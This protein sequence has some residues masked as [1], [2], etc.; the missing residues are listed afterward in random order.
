VHGLV[1]SRQGFEDAL[2]AWSSVE[3]TF[4]DLVA[5]PD[6]PT[7][8][9]AIRNESLADYDG[10]NVVQFEDPFDIIP[11]LSG[12][13]GIV[14]LGGSITLEGNGFIAGNTTFEQTFE[15][16]VVMNQGFGACF[17]A[18]AIA[19]TV[20][21]EIGHT[22][23]FGH[24]SE[25][26]AE[27]DPVLEDAIMYFAIKD[28]GRGAQLG[29]DDVAAMLFAYPP[30]IEEP[31]AEGTALRNAACLLDIDLW[32]GAC[33]VD[34]EELSGFPAAPI[35]QYRKA[36]RLAAKAYAGTKA[37]KQLKLVKKADRLLTKA[38]TKLAQLEADG[39]LRTEC[40]TPLLERVGRAR[41]RIG[42]AR[43]LLEAVL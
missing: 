8:P 31:S 10:L 41:T 17:S 1:A 3:G 12:C 14:A 40:V 38:E 24:S 32:S 6:V 4:L 11:D 42:E 5:G 37:K 34:Q 21:H 7:V 43:T 9:P 35:K 29:S 13:Q 19:E 26:P 2:A 18:S 15:A 22:L 33:F 39:V 27:T 36:A 23:G 20:T 30:P 28:D 16:E 25:N